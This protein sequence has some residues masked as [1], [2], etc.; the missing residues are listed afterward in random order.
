MTIIVAYKGQ[1]WADSKITICGRASTCSKL[2][3]IGDWDTVFA[4]SEQIYNAYVVQ[5]VNCLATGIT[6]GRLQRPVDDSNWTTMYAVRSGADTVYAIELQGS[7]W[8]ASVY[9]PDADMIVSGSGSFFFN[10]Y[11]ALTKDVGKS[12][13]FTATYHDDCGLPVITNK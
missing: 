3:K 6:S 10:A 7:D 1:I 8:V 13:D 9:G 11:Y 12:M 5:V 4:G 2:R